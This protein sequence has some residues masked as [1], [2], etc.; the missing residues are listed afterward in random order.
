MADIEVV[1]RKVTETV[2]SATSQVVMTTVSQASGSVTVTY[3]SVELGRD[4]DNECPICFESLND[5]ETM[6]TPC[7]GAKFHIACLRAVQTNS[8]NV[9]PCPHCRRMLARLWLKNPDHWIG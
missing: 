3:P 2:Q 9:F 5:R 4:P 7:C 1:C 8:G 6:A